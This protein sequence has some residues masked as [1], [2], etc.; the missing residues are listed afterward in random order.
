V[1]SYENLSNSDCRIAFY[2]GGANGRNTIL[3]DGNGE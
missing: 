3:V 1:A 2:N